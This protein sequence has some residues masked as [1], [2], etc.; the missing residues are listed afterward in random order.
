MPWAPPAPTHWLPSLAPSRAQ[1]TRHAYVLGRKTRRAAPPPL[2]T[3]CLTGFSQGGPGQPW[4]E[5]W[6]PRVTHFFPFHMPPRYKAGASPG[7]PSSTPA[8]G[9]SFCIVYIASWM[10]HFYLS[11]NVLW[12]SCDT[13]DSWRNV[14]SRNVELASC[15]TRSLI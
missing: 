4:R 13:W 3:T 10:G 7:H 11:L 5:C 2:H 6:Y 1:T 14:G 12:G 8:A 15:L 9:P